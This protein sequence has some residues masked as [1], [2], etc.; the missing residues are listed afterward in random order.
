MKVHKLKIRPEYFEAV[1]SGAKTFEIHE[2]ADRN[3]NVGDVLEL[4]E[5]DPIAKKYTGEFCSVRVTYML[6]DRNFSGIAPNYAVLGFHY[7][8]DE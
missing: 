2:C 6:T 5:W 4:Q 3:F 7:K 1:E 8:C